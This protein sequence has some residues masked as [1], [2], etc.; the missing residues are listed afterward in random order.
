MKTEI[1]EPLDWSD[2]DAEAADDS[3]TVDRLYDETIAT[4]QAT[5]DRLAAERPNPIR[6]RFGL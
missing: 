1:G 2:L 4:L 6:S 3:E 5:M